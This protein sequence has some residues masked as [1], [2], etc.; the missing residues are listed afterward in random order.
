MTW[1]ERLSS[2]DVTFLNLEADRAAHMH[3]GGLAVFEGP[4]PPYPDVL[5]LIEARLEHVPRYRQ[6]LAMVPLGQGRPVWIDDADF[7]LEYHVRHTALPPPGDDAQLK[8]LAGRLLSQRLDRDKP[9]WEFWF[10]EGMSRNRFAVLSKTHHCMVDGISGV[11]IAAVLMDPEPNHAPPPAPARWVPRPAPS[12]ATLFATSVRDQ[13]THPVQVAREAMQPTSEA[14][15]AVMEIAAGLR[16]LLGLG[17]MGQAPPSS[18]NRAIGPHRRFETLQLDLERVKQVRAAFGVTVND[19]LL[20]TVSGALRTLLQSRG[21]TPPHDLR[22]MV[23]VSVR[24]QEARGTLGNQVTAIFCPLPVDEPDP[25]QRLLRVSREMRGLKETRQAVGALA[26]S[27]LGD[28]TPPTLVAQAARLQSVTRF[29]NLVVT[30]V[31]GPQF[32]LYLLGH[33]LQGCYPAVPLAANTTLGVALLSYDG[34]VGV[35]ILAD[36]DGGK[37]L[38]TFSDGIV[39]ALTQLAE[40]IPD[41]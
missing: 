11:D 30:N 20:A 32:P 12:A 34:Q 39:L 38:E 27:R 16:P 22:V 10:I 5:A 26:L 9:L 35:G 18:L 1:S 2:L 7:D 25:V 4:P 6:R 23:P 3:V 28:F 33:K 14:R 15:K 36:A 29:F 37:D 17:L 41:R 8:R 40:A 31:P 24:S 21:E 13:V 19:V